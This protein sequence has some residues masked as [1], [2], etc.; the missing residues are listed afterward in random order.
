M[1][2]K[3]YDP[4]LKAL[5]ETEPESWPTFLGQPTGAT[6]VR[7]ADIATISG[8]A[9][10]VLHVGAQPPYL[11]HLEFVAGHDAARLPRKLL[12]RN[13][14]LEERHD[15]RARS[16]VLLLRPE[17]DSPKLTGSYERGF[18]GEE[19]YVKFRYQV[20]RIW[21]LLPEPLLTGGLPLLPLAPISAVT[22]ADLPGI[23]QR[24]EQRLRGRAARKQAQVIWGAAYIL[25][26]RPQVLILG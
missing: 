9:D 19:P 18:P 20:I 7:D 5:V 16:A 25:L 15:V 2:D 21:E 13:T 1:T 26:V 8:A 12:A 24:M 3:P 23:I 4:A 11:L 17:A 22:E 6:T 10:K 14:L